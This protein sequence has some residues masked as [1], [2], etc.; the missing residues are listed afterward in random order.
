M[1]FFSLLVVACEKGRDPK[2]LPTVNRGEIDFSGWDFKNNG[3]V[4]LNGEWAFFWQEHLIPIEKIKL[5]HNE[6]VSYIKVPDSWND[7]IVNGKKLSGAGFATYRIH[8]SLPKDHP[9]L[10]VK[11]LDAATA[12]RI[13]LNGFLIKETGVVG[14]T[15][16]ESQPFYSPQVIPLKSIYQN[17]ELLIHV[18]NYDH[19]Q[20][21]L[22]EEILIG[23][24]SQLSD[25]REKSLI[26]DAVLFGIL[27]IVGL[28]HIGLFYSLKQDKSPLF[29]GIFCAVFT[30]RVISHGERYIVTIFPDIEFSVLLKI[31]YLSTYIAVPAFALYALELFPK[32]MSK[33]VVNLFI[34]ISA[35]FCLITLISSPAA[36][37]RIMPFYQ[38]L[39]IILL[40]Y[41]VFVVGR[42]LKRKEQGSLI[43]LFG[44]LALMTTAIIDILNSRLVIH[45]GYHVPFGIAIFTFA[46]AFLISSKFSTAFAIIKKQK[47]DIQKTEALFRAAIENSP[48][49]MIVS[50]DIKEKVVALNHK[51]TEFFGYTI[52]DI[53]NVSAWWP[54]AYPDEEYRKQVS[55]DWEKALIKAS[56][57]KSKS[58]SLEVKITDNNNIQKQVLVTATSEGGYN[59]VAFIDQT[60]QKHREK[61]KEKLISQ[62][63]SAIDEI[64]TLEGIV[65]I[66][67]SCKKIRD[68]K[69]YWNNLES[70]IEHH[71]EASFSHGMCP[72]CSYKFYGNEE[73]YTK[74]KKK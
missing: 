15:P 16:S 17:N 33:K 18:S 32:S 42:A 6:T 20:G 62:L 58:V 8:F 35:L 66:C 71:S 50:K 51:F 19:W 56:Y 48:I 30:L 28:Y 27:S 26:S 60:D 2:Q 37:T 4:A 40:G 64:K 57:G 63:E 12:S 61:E 68:D 25:I 55:K 72:D 1:L 34:V 59:F 14:Q 10:G 5:Q 39:I 13:Y 11:I 41:G 22:W 74:M 3:P 54:L 73:W 49:P 21:G 24:V 67:S 53:P 38:L 69:G 7:F 70:Y 47:Q 31:V 43:F 29:F 52:S 9:E 44:F 46:Q 36:F 45:S 65:P 23:E